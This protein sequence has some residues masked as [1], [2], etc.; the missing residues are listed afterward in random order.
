MMKMGEWLWRD[1]GGKVQKRG[2]LGEE[3]NG[4]SNQ[5]REGNDKANWAQRQEEAETD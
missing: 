4:R 1:N 5:D 3:Q 2:R